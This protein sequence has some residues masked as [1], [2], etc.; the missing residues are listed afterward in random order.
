MLFNF[1]EIIADVPK[2]DLLDI[3]AMDTGESAYRLLLER[4]NARIVG[5]EPVKEECEK[6]QNKWGD[7]HK[8]FP[9]FI[10]DGKPAKYY[11]TNMPM[12][13]SLYK[14]NMKILNHFNNLG[15]LTQTV[16]IHEVETRRLD[17]V[18]EIDN[19]DF[20]KIDIQGGE[21]NVFKGAKK[22]LSACLAIQVEVEFVE[23]YEN[24]PMFADVDTFLRRN[25]FQFHSFISFGMRCFNPVVINNNVN[26]GINQQLWGDAVYVK[27]WMNL[28]SLSTVQLKKYA[29]VMHELYSSAD[30]SHLL[31]R[32]ID[33]REKTNYSELYWLKLT[34]RKN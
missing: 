15:E 10:G 22:A 26:T 11:E 30:L 34:G 23:M 25:G 1:R 3:G 13:G 19:V 31:L 2:I 8:F 6:L 32:E 21:L 14:P 12:T 24:Q 33:R 20:I 16:K 9:Y 5:F 4:N 28:K 7:P 29:L 17:D 27:D 18:V